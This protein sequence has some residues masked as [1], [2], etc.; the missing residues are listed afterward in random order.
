M[1]PSD[2][3]CDTPNAPVMGASQGVSDAPHDAPMLVFDNLVVFSPNCQ[4][5]I[6]GASDAPHD[7][8]VIRSHN[9][10]TLST[11]TPTPPP[12]HHPTSPPIP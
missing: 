1:G 9:T 3:H 12:D 5:I 8:G 7:G 2:A 6:W 4:N 10:T 11:H